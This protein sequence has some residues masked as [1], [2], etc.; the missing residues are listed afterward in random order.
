MHTHMC[1]YTDTEWLRDCLLC[2]YGERLDDL[3]SHYAQTASTG[4]SQLFS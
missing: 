1:V 4:V 2:G 3:V